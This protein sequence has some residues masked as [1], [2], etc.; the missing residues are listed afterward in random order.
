M[1]RATRKLR[2][3]PRHRVAKKKTGKAKTRR[4]NKKKS[5]DKNMRFL[6]AL[7]NNP[8]FRKSLRQKRQLGGG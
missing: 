5:A 7:K 1:P 3:K 8:K 4:S 2:N 6:C